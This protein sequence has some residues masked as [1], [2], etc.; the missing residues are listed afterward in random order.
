MLFNLGATGTDGGL[1]LVDPDVVREASQ[2]TFARGGAGL[3]A[4][5]TSSGKGGGLAN[6]ER[7]IGGGNTAACAGGSDG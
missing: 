1:T 2:S 7:G 3:E 4:P 5:G 6:G